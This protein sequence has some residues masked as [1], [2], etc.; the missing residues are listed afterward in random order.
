[1]LCLTLTNLGVWR[2]ISR[3]TSRENGHIHRLTTKDI[4]RIHRQDVRHERVSP[5]SYICIRDMEAFELIVRN[6]GKLQVVT[7][8]SCFLALY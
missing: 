6:N 3:S 2:V 1:M 8:R 4:E 5:R 7:R